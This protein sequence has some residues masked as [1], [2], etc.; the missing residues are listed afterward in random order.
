M[1]WLPLSF[2]YFGQRSEEDGEKE[3]RASLVATKSERLD[4][5]KSY[6]YLILNKYRILSPPILQFLDSQTSLRASLAIPY[7]MGFPISQVK[8]N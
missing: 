6:I 5:L 7:F 8:M 3:I 4:M 1:R 2:A